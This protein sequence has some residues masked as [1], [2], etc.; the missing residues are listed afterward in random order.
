MTIVYGI[1]NCDTVKK[2]RRWLDDHGV[3]YRF[4]DF[5]ADGLT[6]AQLKGWVAAVGWEALLNRRGTTWRKLP[7]AEREGITAARA[8]RLMLE[9][10]TLIKRPVIEADN[11]VLVGFDEEDYRKRFEKR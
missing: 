2:S 10:P 4:H 1:K 9:E 7:E 3:E 8:E 5:R 6:R 11:T